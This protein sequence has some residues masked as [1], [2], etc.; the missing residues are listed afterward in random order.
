ML[1]GALGALANRDMEILTILRS[2]PIG[3]LT[4]GLSFIA[5]ALLLRKKATDPR[6]LASKASGND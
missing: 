4:L 1:F 2:E 6:R 3:L 5:V